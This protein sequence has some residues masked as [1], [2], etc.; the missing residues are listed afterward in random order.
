MDSTLS[1][2]ILTTVITAAVPVL[3][4]L[5]TALLI[6]ALKRV[7]LDLDAE[8]QAQLEGIVKRAILKVEEVFEAKIKA[9]QPVTAADK[10]SAAVTDVI[11]NAPN[12]TPQQAADAIHAQLPL[13]RAAVTVPFG[14]VLETS[15]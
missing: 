15:K 12:L 3:V 14:A 1:K 11:K 4:T 8:R 7:G 9:G 5:V 6:K 2:E 10:L 13:M